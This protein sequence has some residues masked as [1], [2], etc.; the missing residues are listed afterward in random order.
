MVSASMMGK[1]PIVE[2]AWL[3]VPERA[4]P[5]KLPM[6]AQ[7]PH[8]TM[9]STVQPSQAEVNHRRGFD[10]VSALT[11]KPL[12]NVNQPTDGQEAKR[13]FGYPNALCLL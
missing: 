3:C 2:S 1:I 6:I 4:S 7:I 9:A 13:A 5:I 8:E 12:L 11:Q 10:W